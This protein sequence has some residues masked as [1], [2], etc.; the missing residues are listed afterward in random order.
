MLEGAPKEEF[1]E[2]QDF[3]LEVGLPVTLEEIGVTTPE[4]VKLSTTSQAMYSPLSCM[5]LLCRLTLWVR[6]HSANKHKNNK[7]TGP[8]ALCE[9]GRC[10]VLLSMP[11]MAL[12]LSMF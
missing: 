1:K 3:C 11:T 9:K 8:L 10:F 4:Q 6:L 7:I 12:S 5:T 2:V